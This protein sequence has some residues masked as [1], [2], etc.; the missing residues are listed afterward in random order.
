M[1]RIIGGAI[2][3]GVAVFAGVGAMGDDTTRDDSG[4]IVESGGLGVYSFQIGDCIQFP[5]G[6]EQ[7][8]ESV[9][10]VPGSEPHD[11]QVYVE[12]DLAA[13]TFPGDDAIFEAA[14][15]RCYA[16]FDAAMGVAYD[17][18]PDLDF[19]A[20][21]PVEEGWDAGDREVTCF[22]VRT[23]YAKWTGTALAADLG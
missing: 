23:D 15:A 21:T 4:D 16:E 8:V 13:E 11:A 12:F 9:E 20:F 6:D 7:L 14:A 3:A 5:V 10:G 1:R 17:A 18:T 2:A 22:V 19:T